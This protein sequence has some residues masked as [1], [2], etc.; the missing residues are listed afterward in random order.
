MNTMKRATTALVIILAMV[1][2]LPLHAEK[3]RTEKIKLP[4]LQC[5]MCKETI[6]SKMKKVKGLK[7]IVV[8]VD[9]LS[10]TV[11]YDADAVTLAKI[12]KSIADIG[13]DANE[14]RARRN[15]QRKL[16]KCC[17]PGAHR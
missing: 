1:M 6:E 15:A 11:E 7:S 4:T 14:T 12:E 8:D 17:Q 9:D 2:A 5:G 3:I 10:A 16:D 13:Y